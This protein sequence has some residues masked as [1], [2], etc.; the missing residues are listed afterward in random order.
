MPIVVAQF[1]LPILWFAHAD[2]C[3]HYMRIYL[4]VILL[5]MSCAP[6][7]AVETDLAGVK[8]TTLFHE[9]TDSLQAATLRG[10]NLHE[11]L[12][13][14]A[15]TQLGVR[16][17][18]CSTDP[19]NGF[20]CSGFVNFVF[21]HFLIHV[22]RSSVEF[23]NLGTSI[24]LKKAL[25]GDLILFTGTDPRKPVVGHIGIVIANNPDSLNFIHASSGAAYSVTISPLDKYYMSRFVKIIR[26]DY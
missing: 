10:Q 2:P 20:D 25:P 21:N 11:E 18:Y 26:L 24:D 8:D 16:Y 13:A 15:K 23:T 12:V 22:P 17:R 1:L 19:V 5:F 3:H 14:F 6:K 7:P 9:F 4:L